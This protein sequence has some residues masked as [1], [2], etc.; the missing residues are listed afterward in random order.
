[1]SVSNPWLTPYQRSFES[2]KAKLVSQMRLNVPEVTDFSEGNIFMI[3]ISIFA[4][5]A[6]VL[7]YYIDNMARE[8]F[9]TTARRYSSVIK[10]AKAFDYHI[11]LANPASIDVYLKQKDG[12]PLPNNGTNG[13][14]FSVNDDAFTDSK[15]NEWRLSTNSFWEA[16]TYSAVLPLA[17]YSASKTETYNNYSQGSVLYLPSLSGDELYAE[18]YFTCKVGDVTWELVDTFAHSKAND[19]H[20]MV[21]LD[22]NLKPYVK[23]G[24]GIFG[25]IPANGSTITIGYRTTKGD[26]G[27]IEANG[28]TGL[29]DSITKEAPNAVISYSTP[30]T[31][32]TPYETFDMIKAHLPLA[33]R[34]MGVA[35]S[36]Q[37]Y[38]DLVETFP[39]ISKAYAQYLCG[40]QVE[41]Y[42]TPF[43]GT[44]ASTDLTEK[45]KKLLEKSKLIS[46]EAE[47]YSTVEAY[48]YIDAD[49]TGK[50]SIKFTDINSEVTEALVEAYSWRNSSPSRTVR[51]S[52]LYA[53]IDNL[54]TVDY[55]IL[56]SAYIVGRPYAKGHENGII[57]LNF[58][59]TRDDFTSAD[60]IPEDFTYSFQVD[61]NTV[62]GNDT[63]LKNEWGDSITVEYW[64]QGR[65]NEDEGDQFPFGTPARIT[66]TLGDKKLIFEFTFSVIPYGDT[67]GNSTNYEFKISRNLL[68]KQELKPSG[69]NIPIIT[70]NTLKLNINEQV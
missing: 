54:P 69:Y 63:I 49:I 5:I 35:V 50:K 6:E 8:T 57:V 51:L 7:H 15:G 43:G 64:Y 16:G 30:G 33:V 26:G 2:I 36:K 10:H 11:K 9:F 31:G 3:I 45:V 44:Q 14:A 37:D 70:A 34:T 32:G 24:D 65:W 55:L 58:E 18:G 27:N 17:Q 28:I 40:R 29:I 60:N 67:G 38:I 1:M 66:T 12:S 22:I 61:D 25:S 42:I 39:G 68:A 59:I 20:F 48:I 52:D 23:F 56:N 19:T 21:E 53:L 46:V 47:V 62:D 41:I 4:A 13:I